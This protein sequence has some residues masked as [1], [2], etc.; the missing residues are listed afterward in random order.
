MAN[1][2]SALKKLLRSFFEATEKIMDA[3]TELTQKNKPLNAF[4][5]NPTVRKAA[6]WLTLFS[7][8]TTDLV[9]IRAFLVPGKS[10]K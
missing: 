5:A 10:K 6:P 1:E 9:L 3:L 4:F 2:L 8:F 7:F